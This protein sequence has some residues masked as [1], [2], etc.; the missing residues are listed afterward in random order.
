MD[1]LDPV[2]IP[3][4]RV[5]APIDGGQSIDVHTRDEGDRTTRVRTV[6][7]GIGSDHRGEGRPLILQDDPLGGGLTNGGDRTQRGQ[8]A[9]AGLGRNADRHLG[10]RGQEGQLP[11]RG[12]D[13]S[14]TRHMRRE[15]EPFVEGG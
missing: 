2:V 3:G 10:H 5:S 1:L 13:G 15:R 11:I 6:I 4:D 14:R 7:E 12:L 9:G 8:P